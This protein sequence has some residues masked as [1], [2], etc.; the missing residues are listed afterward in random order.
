MGMIRANEENVVLRRNTRDP[1]TLMDLLNIALRN[2]YKVDGTNDDETY[3]HGL[4]V[5]LHDY[6]LQ[7]LQWMIDEENDPIGF[8]RHFYKKGNFADRTPFYYSTLFRILTVNQ[9][10][11]MVH[12]GFLCEEMARQ[13]CSGF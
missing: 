8:Y 7:S 13:A 1:D 2:E 11:P 5:V 6:Q 4:N 12:G 10:L 3:N 9:P